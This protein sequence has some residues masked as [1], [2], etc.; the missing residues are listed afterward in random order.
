PTNHKDTPD[1]DTNHNS[2]DEDTDSHHPHDAHDAHDNKAEGGD[3][4]GHDDGHHNS[5]DEDGPDHERDQHDDDAADSHNGDVDSS[6]PPDTQPGDDPLSGPVVYKA[7]PNA[8]P[9]EIQ[10]FR[11]YVDGCNRALDAG[12]LS[13]TGRVSTAGELRDQASSAAKAERALH[14]DLYEG[15][16]VGHV[17]DTTWTA[18]PIPHEWQAMSKRVNSSLGGQANRY[19]W[20][21]KPTEFRFDEGE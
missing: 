13:E 12:E 17:P 10:E 2:N 6:E 3:D 19:P 18:D 8:T 14:P 11:D 15:K 9:E 7:Y 4:R 20:G 16:A 1:T 21:Y 5:Q